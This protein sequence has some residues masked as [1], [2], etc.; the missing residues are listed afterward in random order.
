MSAGETPLP[1]EP[2]VSL[3]MRAAKKIREDADRCGDPPGSFMPE[4]AG[5]LEATAGCGCEEDGDHWEQK[6]AALAVAR[7]YLNETEA[8]GAGRGA[9]RARGR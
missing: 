5:L 2:P 4:V 3:L 8:E 1:G 9:L 6:A 7:G